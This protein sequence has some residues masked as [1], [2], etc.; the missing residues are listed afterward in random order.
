M[1]KGKIKQYGLSEVTADQIRRAHKIH[2]VS[3][4]QI[5]YAP[6]S[7]EDEQNDVIKTCKE[8]GITIVAYS[9]LGRAFFTKAN[10][11][12]FKE[13]KQDDFRSQ[14][15]RYQGDTLQKNLKAKEALQQY[16]DKKNCSLAQLVLAWE[17]AKGII[18]IPATVNVK[19]LTENMLALTI[20]LSASEFEEI[21]KIIL[22]C[23]F[24]GPR[25]PDAN[26]SAIHPERRRK[27]P[28]PANIPSASP[29]KVKSEIRM[30]KFGELGHIR[31]WGKPS[32][33][34]RFE[35]PTA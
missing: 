16:A 3:A 32:E 1:L 2:P 20:K 33:L 7:R 30:M 9:P 14:L 35:K 21:Q 10:A 13:L 4:V 31:L 5:E 26:F 22:S 23:Q 15:P 6:W 34:K 19:H 24:V 29:I 28:Q 11:S 27:L 12:F 18:P 25:Y 17:M 8:L